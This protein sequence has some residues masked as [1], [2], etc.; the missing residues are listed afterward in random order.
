MKNLFYSIMLVPLTACA[1]IVVPQATGGSRADGVVEF[2]YSYG[3]YQSPRPDWVTADRQAVSRCGAWGYT[4]AQRF[5]GETR[6]CSNSFNG[7][8]NRWIVTV[9]YQCSGSADS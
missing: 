8:C 4:G 2:S 7:S 5:G 1:T 9:S 6:Q 3:G